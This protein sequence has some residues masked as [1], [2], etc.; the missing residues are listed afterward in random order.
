M[1]SLHREVD[2]SKEEDSKYSLYKLSSPDL[3]RGDADKLFMMDY[4][5]G[6]A[7]N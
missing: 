2:H 5:G 1:K 3:N 6:Y 7:S 4:W